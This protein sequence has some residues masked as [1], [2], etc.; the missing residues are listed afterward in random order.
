MKIDRDLIQ[1]GTAIAEN[2]TR[3]IE[4][5]DHINSS[6]ALNFPAIKN[7]LPA[8]CNTVIKAVA[9]GNL[10]LV[11]TTPASRGYHH[12]LTR[13]RQDFQPKE[14]V[15]EFSLLRQVVL[16]ELTPQ[17][18]NFDPEEIIECIKLSDLIIERILENSFQSYAEVRQQQLDNLTQQIFLTNQEINRLIADHQ[19]RLSYLVHEIKNPLTSIIGYSDLFLRNQQQQREEVA[20]LEHIQ[21]VLKQGR[22]LLR[23][24]N[25]TLEIDSYQKGDLKLRVQQ[26]EVCTLLEDIIIGLKPSIEAKKL[27]LIDFLHE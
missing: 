17:L 14:L 27:Q 13:S 7:N 25:D 11:G 26:I 22:N 3:L 18:L 8:I 20:D 16:A 1:D 5:D 15:R 6:D 12:G 10:S 21:Q 24:I 4:E 9:E 2:L 23:I 19:E